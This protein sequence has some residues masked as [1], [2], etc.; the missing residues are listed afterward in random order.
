MPSEGT[1]E[2]EK[3]LEETGGASGLPGF[4]YRAHLAATKVLKLNNKV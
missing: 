3:L 1:A 2:Y 4:N